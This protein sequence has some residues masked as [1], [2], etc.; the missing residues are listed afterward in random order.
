MVVSSDNT[1]LNLERHVGTY[2]RIVGIQAGILLQ[3]LSYSD[4]RRLVAIDDEDVE[5]TGEDPLSTILVDGLDDLA[6]DREAEIR[7]KGSVA[8]LF[9][10][11]ELQ[12]S[13]RPRLLGAYPLRGGDVALGGALVSC[14]YTRDEALGTTLFTQEYCA[15]H[16]LPRFDVRWAF[17][18]VVASARPPCGA[19]LVVTA[20]LEAARRRC[21]GVCAVAATGAGHRLLRAL[22]FTCHAY[23]ERGTQRHMCYLR[24][25]GDLSFAAI[26]RKLRLE[27]DAAS[28]VE[29]V[30]WREPLS[31]RAKYSVIGR[32]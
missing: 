19:L 3:K 8:A 9:E 26:K 23:R 31:A 27:G 16:G 1:D 20:M 24:L 6:D 15:R 2:A 32:C 21:A 25:P 5:A 7:P 10:H 30:C 4:V 17:I 28:I 13:L 18:D 22:N 14:L 11:G 29:S 12:R